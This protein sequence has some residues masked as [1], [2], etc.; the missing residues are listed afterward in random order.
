MDTINTSE[1]QLLAK[2][3]SDTNLRQFFEAQTR[4]IDEECFTED[5]TLK[6]WE[7]IVNHVK[8]YKTLPSLRTVQEQIPTF[9][10]G[11]APERLE[12]YQDKVILQKQKSTMAGLIQDIALLLQEDRTEKALELIS[13]KY[14]DLIRDIK[15]SDFGSFREMLDRII[16]YEKRV[17]SGENPMGVP[18]GI[19]EL[20]E[21]FL[22]FRPGDYAVLSGRPGEG[23]TTLALSMG[24]NAFIAGYKV[25]YITLEMPRE[26]IF[27]KLDALATGISINKIKR[28]SLTK[29]ELARYKRRAEQLHGAESDIRV[30]DRTG[31]CGIVTIEAILNQDE[32]DILFVDPIYLMKGSGKKNE[33]QNIKDNSNSLKRL[34]IQY[35][36]PIVITS[37]INRAGK[38]SIIAGE[39]PTIENL[40]YSDALGQDADHAFVLTGNARTRFYKTKRLTSIKLRGAEPKDIVVKWDPKTN[41]VEYFCEYSKLPSPDQEAQEV[42]KLQNTHAASAKDPLDDNAK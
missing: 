41:F 18:T 1:A 2:I 4:G 42:I 19:K 15:M 25:S 9:S 23:K 8:Q 34:A 5:A 40:S 14:Q 29:E 17:S 22:G 10:P 37:Q 35:R 12:Y 36:R 28:M 16:E 26:Q 31:D 27:E 38:D 6:A 11:E 32:P 30:H 24:F 39:S 20:D 7:F 3:I 33:W 21:H 13:D